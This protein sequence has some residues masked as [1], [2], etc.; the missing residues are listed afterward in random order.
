MTG[1]QRFDF[2]VVDRHLLTGA[3]GGD[4]RVDLHFDLLGKLVAAL[5]IREAQVHDVQPGCQPRRVEINLDFSTNDER[6]HVDRAAA[7]C[8][9]RRAD[10]PRRVER[11][12]RAGRLRRHAQG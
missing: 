6:L 11:D 3:W 7:G 8:R 2:E 9:D 1:R 4:R 10:L 5:R 12:R